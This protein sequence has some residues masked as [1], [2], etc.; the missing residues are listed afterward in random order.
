MNY[1]EWLRAGS[2]RHI[3]QAGSGEGFRIRPCSDSEEDRRAFQDVAREALAN[4]GNG[5]F[6]KEHLAGTWGLKDWD[7]AVYD[8]VAIV[9]TP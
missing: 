8:F 3:V 2:S 4:A 1:L 5:Y 6:A 7:R 9:P